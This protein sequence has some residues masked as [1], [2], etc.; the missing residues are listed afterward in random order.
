M[1]RIPVVAFYS[2]P[3]QIGPGE[4][5]SFLYNGYRVFMRVKLPG[6]GVDH[7]PPSSAEVEERVE[8]YIYCPSGFLW[9]VL[10]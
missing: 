6:R 5:L 2:I 1:D 9:A 3:L 4:K 10:G 7:P 8:L